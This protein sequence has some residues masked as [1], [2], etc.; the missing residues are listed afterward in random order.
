MIINHFV[1]S[2]FYQFCYKFEFSAGDNSIPG[3]GLAKVGTDLV[4]HLLKDNENATF[5]V[6]NGYDLEEFSII[7]RRKII[8]VYKN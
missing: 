8:K 5:S 1:T 2:E 6:V 3:M 7:S 4:K